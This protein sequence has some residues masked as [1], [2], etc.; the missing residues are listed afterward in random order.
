MMAPRALPLLLAAGL[1]SSADAAKSTAL[2]TVELQVQ[3][4]LNKALHEL[5]KKHNEKG[6]HED[7]CSAIGF[8]ELNRAPNLNV[9]YPEPNSNELS[10]D[11][12]IYT[13][14]DKAYCNNDECYLIVAEWTMTGTEEGELLPVVTQEWTFGARCFSEAEVSINPSNPYGNYL[15]KI[16]LIKPPKEKLKLVDA[17]PQR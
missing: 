6:R 7:D 15:S 4:K 5:S 8:W 2:E 10:I 16:S 11:D 12:T 9:K 13:W 14:R 3:A 1:L 17:S